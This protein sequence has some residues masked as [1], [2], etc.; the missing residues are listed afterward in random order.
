VR[1]TTGPLR[2][3]APTPS[4]DG[5]SVFAVGVE[6]RVELFSYEPQTQRFDSYLGGLS[7]SGVAFS[8]DGKWIAWVSYPDMTLWKSRPD[9]S[10][11]M[12]LTFPPVRAYAPRWS[13]DAS[14]IAF[15]DMQP[16]RPW[17]AY[18]LSSSGGDS[19]EP[20]AHSAIDD[21]NTDPTWTPDGK[22]I[23]LSRAS[24]GG[25]GESAIYRVDLSNGNLVQIPGSSGFSSPRL[26]PDGQH[27]AAFALNAKKLMLFDQN[28]NSWSTLAEGEFGN[29]EWAPDGKYVYARESS[30]GFGR[31][32]RVGIKDRV[33]GRG[34]EPQRF[35]PA[36]GYVRRLVWPDPGW[37]IAPDARPQR[38]GSLCH[39]S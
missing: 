17:Q 26:S 10:E 13:P 28:T 30:K 6:S 14:R 25:A 24:A 8:S 23:I 19:P 18:V 1:L 2:F 35:S 34:P 15:S 21:M 7:A 22:S 39:Q 36:C 5:K 4:L 16:H 38:P 37:K 31:I 3:G 33:F 20:I 9:M 29:N 27:I 12:Q 11:K 32:V